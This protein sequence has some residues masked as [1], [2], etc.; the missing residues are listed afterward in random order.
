MQIL[1]SIATELITNDPKTQPTQFLWEANCAIYSVAYTWKTKH[2][3]TRIIQQNQNK[4]KPKWMKHIESQMNLLRREILQITE[5]IKRLKTNGRITRK[6]G[7]NRKWMRQ[8]LKGQLSIKASLILKET[9]T[10]LIRTLKYRKQKKIE[11]FEKHQFNKLFDNSQGKVYDKF[12][13]ILSEDRD[14]DQPLYKTR[15]RQAKHGETTREEVE[16]FW[17]PIWEDMKEVKLDADWIN[18]VTNNINNR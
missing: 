11:R 2:Q 18:T 6:V 16:K 3:K 5:E 4:F 13:D 12:R 9:K 8:E 10:S 1:K 15:P 7:R 14:N 17:R